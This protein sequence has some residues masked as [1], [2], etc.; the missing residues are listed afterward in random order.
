MVHTQG[1]ARLLKIVFC[2]FLSDQDI[3]TKCQIKF[4]LQ[5]EKSRVNTIRRRNNKTPPVKAISTPQGL[6]PRVPTI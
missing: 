5:K 1:S 4:N 6:R 2:V 3:D